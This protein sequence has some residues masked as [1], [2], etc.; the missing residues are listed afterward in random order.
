MR[1]FRGN[2]RLLTSS[3][4]GMSCFLTAC[5]ARK[6]DAARKIQPC[7]CLM[8]PG[9]LVCF[10][11]GEGSKGRVSMKHVCLS[12]LVVMLWCVMSNAQSSKTELKGRQSANPQPYCTPEGCDVGDTGAAAASTKAN[13]NE[14]LAFQLFDVYGRQVDSADYAGVPVL[15]FFGS[16]W[17]GG[18]MEDT[19][20]FRQLAGEYAG[21]GLVCLRTVAGD[22]ELAALDFQNHFRLPMAHLMDPDRA[23]ESKRYGGCLLCRRAGARVECGNEE[24]YCRSPSLHAQGNFWLDPALPCQR[25]GLGFFCRAAR[26][27]AEPVALLG[28]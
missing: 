12:I 25:S 4:T 2:L 27:I 16:C 5:Q 6:T 28:L 14:V 22:N 18:C 15:I 13:P 19:K 17:C 26:F 11:Y 23:F 8:V 10:S 1:C 3:P 21:K 9:D 24:R 7:R 20:P